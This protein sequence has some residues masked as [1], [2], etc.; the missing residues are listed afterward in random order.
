MDKQALLV[1]DVQNDF[2]P[3][4]ALPVAG[5]ECVVPVI[6]GLIERSVR[7]GLPIIATRD[8]HPADHCSFEPRGGTWPE[9]CIA[10]SPGAEFHPALRLPASTQ[11][12]SPPKV[13]FS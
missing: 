3:G 7:A 2:C 8:W 1:V 13:S 4:G 5:G 12:L 6:N 10:H 9:H 11:P